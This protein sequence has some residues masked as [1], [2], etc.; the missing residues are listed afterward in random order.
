MSSSVE[1]APLTP[2]RAHAEHYQELHSAPEDTLSRCLAASSVGVAVIDHAQN[3]IQANEAFEKLFDLHARDE[4]KALVRS[5]E[6]LSSSAAKA[7]ELL[8][9]QPEGAS[10]QIE[11]PKHNII[12][13]HVAVQEGATRLLVAHNT[14]P[15]SMDEQVS[16]H[17][18]SRDPLTQLGNR[19]A[20]EV[21][22]RQW[23]ASRSEE[24][25]LALI[26]IDLD[27]FKQVN[28]TLG[29]AIG[30]ALLQV[31][32]A[33][34]RSAT[35]GNDIVIR[36]GGDEFVIVHTTG[37]QPEGAISIG[38]RIV[39]LMSR[40]FI[41]EGHQ[42]NIGASVGIALSQPEV[43]DPAEILR[44]ADLALYEAKAAGRGAWRLFEPHMAQ[45]ALE[46]H[47]MEV[48]LRRALVLKEFS[49]HY[50]P[51]VT[52]NDGR[53]TGFEALIRWNNPERGLVSPGDFIPLAEEIGE[54]HA[55]GEWAIREACRHAVTWPGELAVAV[56]VSPL[57]FQQGD[58]VDIVR[59]ALAATG[60]APK[61]LE[62]EITESVLMADT[63]AILHSL[64]A[65]RELG[66]GIAMD[67]FGTGYSSLSYLNSFPFSKLKIDQS[68]IQ[69]RQ[70]EKSQALINAILKLGQSLGMT[71]IAEG[72]ET[73]GQYQALASSGCVS[74]QGYLIS[75]PM[76]HDRIVA[77]LAGGD[78]RLVQ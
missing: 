16:L 70:S 78:F 46:R 72:I 52:L 7:L 47:A 49:L 10:L 31:V 4:E 21:V 18:F 17:A 15:C 8:L 33:R 23:Q 2:D 9:G 32:A 59:H 45:Q 24:S 5:V 22:T 11:G 56:N 25:T 50:Q 39:E 37:G 65:L 67:D 58:I 66:V 42:L 62:L 20:F 71:T 75:R 3:V 54:I 12:N 13:L 41:V 40:T 68:F 55:I 73:G 76:P 1:N 53:I 29:H 30:D 77:Y 14:G 48:S 43:D 36:L 27:R 26:M 57:Q 61:R 63:D 35:R 34:L 60:L 38:Q 64:W 28:D 74:A 69:S 19:T 6:R 44:R 51:Q